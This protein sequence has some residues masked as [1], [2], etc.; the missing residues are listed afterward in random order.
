[1]LCLK[2]AG[3]EPE[4]GEGCAEL[5]ERLEEYYGGLCDAPLYEVFSYVLTAEFGSELSA[6]ELHTVAD[7]AIRF[8][9]SVYGGLNPFEKLYWRYIKRLI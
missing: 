2:I 3:Q 5:A 1:M 6:D 4:E 7:F 9:P 8:V